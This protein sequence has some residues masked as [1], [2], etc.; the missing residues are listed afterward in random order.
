MARATQA[1]Y[2]L[3]SERTLAHDGDP[4]QNRHMRA[5]STKFIRGGLMLAKSQRG[6]KVDFAIALLMAVGEALSPSESE[7]IVMYVPGRG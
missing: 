4:V 2:E 1:V 6:R 7:G 5:V 3:V